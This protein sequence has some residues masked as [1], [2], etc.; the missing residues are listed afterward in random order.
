[1]CHTGCGTLCRRCVRCPTGLCYAEVGV[2]AFSFVLE[3]REGLLLG[4][5]GGWQ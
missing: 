5:R 3:I 1:M 4:S 2:L